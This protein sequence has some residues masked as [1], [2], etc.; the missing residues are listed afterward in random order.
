MYNE[1]GNHTIDK[2]T[3]IDIFNNNKNIFLLE[4]NMIQNDNTYFMSRARDFLIINKNLLQKTGFMISNIDP[5]K[6]F[7]YL[8]L[9][10]INNN[11]KMLKLPYITSA[12][13]LNKHTEYDYI[14]LNT[15]I[16]LNTDFNK[17]INYKVYDIINN[18]SNIIIRNQVK[19]IKGYNTAHTVSENQN[20]KNKIIDL[21]NIINNLKKN[22]Q[23]NTEKINHHE[24]D[25]LNNQYLNLKDK[26][27]QIEENFNHL[28]FLHSE[29][30][31]KY[32]DLLIK[33]KE[34]KDN[35][36]IKLY[37]IINFEIDN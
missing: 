23:I 31:N 1:Y 13:I 4:K 9:N 34:T 28:N 11:I 27:E 8:I 37:D 15:N 35:I 7:Q 10:L 6:T 19:T 5:N 17:F 26:Y 29:L 21:N 2:E 32:N 14:D 16:D 18:K 20:L 12:Y 24:Y 30:L 25:I 22:N 3:F 33:H 36:L